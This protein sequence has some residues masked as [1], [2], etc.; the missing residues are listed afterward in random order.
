MAAEKERYRRQ[1]EMCTKEA[2]PLIEAFADSAELPEYSHE[3]QVH[4]TVLNLKAIA[5]G[6]RFSIEV[7]P[8]WTGHHRILLVKYPGRAG[9]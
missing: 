4:E 8:S 5:P 3:Q 7:S 2:E 9:T 1:G 6:P